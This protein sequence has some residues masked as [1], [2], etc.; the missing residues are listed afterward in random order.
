MSLIDLSEAEFTVAD[1]AELLR[2]QLGEVIGHADV[3]LLQIRNTVRQYGRTA[4]VTELG[5]NAAAMLT[6]YAKLKEAIEA[7]K[8]IT[9]EDLPN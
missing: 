6:V 3:S 2:Q 4:I 7:A 1:A 9:V 8:E 5:T